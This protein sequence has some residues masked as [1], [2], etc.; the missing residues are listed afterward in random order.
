VT[1]FLDRKTGTEHKRTTPAHKTGVG[2][3]VPPR[4]ADEGILPTLISGAEKGLDALSKAIGSYA[5]QRGREE[6]AFGATLQKALAEAAKDTIKSQTV[7]LV[8]KAPL[9]K[10]ILVTI[11][12]ADVF[13]DGVG[14]AILQV[15]QQILKEQE[16]AFARLP[17]ELDEQA[18]RDIRQ[19][20]SSYQ[21]RAAQELP[22]V[23]GAGVV[24]LA[25]QAV[26]EI[27]KGG[28]NLVQ[29]VV[30]DAI[31]QLTNQLLKQS[32]PFAIFSQA[33]REA[34]ES[35]PEARRRV[36]SLSFSFAATTFI[37]QLSN[38]RLRKS[39]EGIQPLISAVGGKEENIDVAILSSI[40][41][42]LVDKSF[43]LYAKAVGV[44]E[45]RGEV[46]L[47]LLE[48]ARI[49]VKRSG[50]PIT[51]ASGNTVVASL[52]SISVPQTLHADITRPPGDPTPELEARFRRRDREF[53]ALVQ[54]LR[55]TLD[56]KAVL[57]QLRI[58]RRNLESERR[59]ARGEEFIDV[60]KE[61]MKLQNQLVD[62][63][64]AAR[65]RVEQVRDIIV[66]EF[67]KTF[68]RGTITIQL[69]MTIESPERGLRRGEVPRPLVN[70]PAGTTGSPGPP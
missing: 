26:K 45:A 47:A 51:L 67:G 5:T 16:D 12:L 43:E 64:N 30:K 25:D 23:L 52:L 44:P 36:E 53:I 38:E 2:E 4:S 17:A 46:E 63:A 29:K 69:D 13:A 60:D 49:L 3:A 8:E 19:S 65:R 6:A 42:I 28:I 10:A 68:A 54:G 55:A 32:E 48:Q 41:Q 62:E 59:V 7:A 34:S 20:F 58:D 18:I 50:I 39:F 57:F 61:R 37:R 70:R 9:G 66:A 27:L 56:A 31:G 35:I 33:V 24:A 11:R 15:H 22:R 14:A 21:L 40:I 1:E